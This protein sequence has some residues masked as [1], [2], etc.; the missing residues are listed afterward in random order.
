MIGEIRLPHLLRRAI[1]EVRHAVRDAGSLSADLVGRTPCALREQSETLECES[2]GRSHDG[3]DDHSLPGLAHCFLHVRG[4]MGTATRPASAPWRG[5][6][7]SAAPKNRKGPP[8]RAF[9]SN[10]ARLPSGVAPAGE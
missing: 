2:D 8:K 1:Q 3:S 9:P 5:Y 7:S 10:R 6:Q 4:T